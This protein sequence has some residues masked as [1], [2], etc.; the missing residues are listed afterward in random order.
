MM[1]ALFYQIGPTRNSGFHFFLDG[2]AKKKKKSPS[3]TIGPLI[4]SSTFA[5]LLNLY[6]MQ[7]M[8]ISTLLVLAVS[9]TRV[10][11]EPNMNYMA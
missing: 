5:I 9:K 10:M 4:E 2:L 11:H 1:A 8:T 7:H 6:H 3:V